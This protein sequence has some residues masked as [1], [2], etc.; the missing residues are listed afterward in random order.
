[1]RRVAS[2]IVERRRE[3]EGA[4]ATIC[5]ASACNVRRASRRERRV[6]IVARPGARADGSIVLN[7]QWPT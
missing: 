6:S 4:Q 3:A 5:R 1:M 7:T 2:R